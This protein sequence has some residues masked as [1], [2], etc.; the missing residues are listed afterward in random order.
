MLAFV[1]GA[2]LAATDPVAVIATFKRLGVP[3][4]LGT[5]VTAE[6][7]FND[8]TGIVVFALALQAVRSGPDVGGGL[9]G[10]VTIVA[11]S[12][13]IGLAAGWVASRVIATIDDHLV[14]LTISLGA[15][16]G[17]YF[18]ADRLHESGIIATVVAGL[19]IG[20]Y[21]R[22]I[23]MKTRTREALDLVWEFL[24]FLLTAFTFL[25]VGLAVSPGGLAAA[26]PQIAWG[27]GALLVGRAVVVYGLLGGVAV[28]L[29]DRHVLP[30]P[31]LHVLFWA[32]LRGA[33]AIA[34]TLSLPADLPDRALLA[35]TAY[36]IVL[37][38][39]VT[40]GTTVSWV[41]RRTGV[42]AEARREADGA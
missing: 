3:R 27:F 1:V 40:Q 25:L 35:G 12:L 17:T 20:T 41:L 33:V 24:A 30:V 7:L 6:S 2:I 29:P 11:I 19:V 37:L 4:R 39:L 13:G 21:G 5:V 23:G 22:R 26:L 15:A 42:A 32:G 9:V 28:V 38:T 36:G 14:E 10:F 31:W 8:G 16:Y 34:L 18:L